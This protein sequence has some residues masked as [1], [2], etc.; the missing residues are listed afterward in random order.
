[1]ATSMAS[2]HSVAGDPVG[3][4]RRVY[5]YIDVHRYHLLR[6]LK[7][8][9]TDRP[10]GV[11]VFESLQDKFGFQAGN[12]ANQKE[13]LGHWVL[14]I[15]IRQQ[16]YA[17]ARA[18]AN[19]NV[20]S[21]RGTNTDSSVPASNQSKDSTNMDDGWDS[22]DLDTDD[23]NV[24]IHETMSPTLDA[25][26]A[27]RLGTMN[28]SEEQP[29]VQRFSGLHVSESLKEVQRKL[30]KNYLNWCDFVGVPEHEVHV[31]LDERKQLLR[32]RQ[33]ALWLLIWG[34]SANVRFMPE[35][36][37]FIY[38]NMAQGLDEVDL[39]HGEH[40]GLSVNFLDDVVTPI[41]RLM[42]DM[43]HNAR[44]D[45]PNPL[46]HKDVVNY[47]DVNEFFWSPVCLQFDHL[48]VASGIQARDFKKT[49]REKR[50]VFNPMLAF[51]RIWFFLVV[52][53]HI[54]VVIGYVAYR[55][56]PPNPSGFAFYDNIFASEMTDVRC[57][58]IYSIFVTISGLLLLKVVLQMWLHGM[59]LFKDAWLATGVFF[60]LVWHCF[61]VA[62]F[63]M[64]NLAPNEPF[65]IS[66]VAS[67][68]PVG[69]APG[70]YLACGAFFVLIYCI[71][72]LISAT[73]RMCF[74]NSL[75]RWAWFSG[76]DG[77]R[78]QYVGRDMRQP[79]KYTVMYGL[80]WLVILT[81]KCLFCLQCMV[82]PLIGSTIEIYDLKY[83]ANAHSN[84]NSVD[85]HN[86]L[87]ILALW[88]PI[89]IVFMYDS[90]IWFIVYQAIVGLIMGLF[91]KIGHCDT[92]TDFR[93]A[94]YKG[95]DL[96]DRTVAS[97]RMR[98][99]LLLIT[100]RDT[101]YESMRL[102]FAIVWNEIVERLWQGDLVSRR[103]LRNLQYRIVDNGEKVED[104]VFV[105]TGKL[106]KAIEIASKAEARKWD[107]RDLVRKFVE[108]DVMDG[109]QNGLELVKSIFYLI[110]GDKKIEPAVR[111]FDAFFTSLD[112]TK[113]VDFTNLPQLARHVEELLWEI[114]DAPR[115]LD[116]LH[117]PSNH[118]DDQDLGAEAR[119]HLDAYLAHVRKVVECMSNVRTTLRGMLREKRLRKRLDTCRFLKTDEN[120]NYD[121]TFAH[122]RSRL[123]E[124]YR[125]SSKR[126]ASTSEVLL[127]CER[128]GF[129]SSFI[130]ASPDTRGQADFLSSCIRLLSLLR[131]DDSLPRCEE[132]QRRL[133]FFLRSLSMK[134]PSVLSLRAM[135]SFAVMTPY[136]SE[137][138]MYN[139]EELHTEVET[140]APF[141]NVQLYK[142]NKVTT[143][144]YLIS[145]NRDEWNNFLE[146]MEI[147][148]T[149]KDMDKYDH[150]DELRLIR[151]ALSRVPD[152]VR[153]WA[154]MRAQ[155]LAR[156]VMGM[157]MY[158]DA[159]KLLRWLEIGNTP[160]SV[161]KKQKRTHIA[162]LKFSYI[163]GCQIFGKQRAEGKQQAH[164]I[165][166]LMRRFPSWRVSYMDEVMVNNTMQYY[167]VLCKA[168]GTEIVEIYRYRLPG[169]PILGEGKPENQNIALP[170]TRGEYIQTIDMNQEHYF[171]E[172][173]KI[174]NFL[175][176]A[177]S[178]GEEVTIIGMK[179]H[180][181]TGRA[182]SLARFMTMQELVFV[183]L[184]QRV[185]AKPL[186]SR[187]HYGHPD[188]FDKSFVMAN[189]GVSKA[190][191]GINLSEDVFSGYNVTLRGGVVTH[192]EFMQCGKGRDVTLSQIN[193]FETKLS[194]GCA[195][196]CLSREGH[197]LSNSLDFFRLNSMYY[198]HF[199]FY[200]CNALT[201]FCVYI[202]AYAKLYITT[203]D[204]IEAMAA[205]TSGSLDA[206]A[207]VINTQYILQFGF[208]TV[209]P[210]MATL[211]VEFGFKQA[212]FKNTEL[213]GALGVVFY[214]FLTGTK[215]HAF[216]SALIRGG[217]KY[218]ATGRGFSITRDP[219]VTFFKLYGVSHFRKA[220]ELI[221]IM[222][223]VGIFG[224][225]NV[226]ATA[227]STFCASADFSCSDH[228]E[229]IP[230][231][232]T[233]L[234]AFASSGQ[235]FGTTSFAVLLLGSCWLLAPFVFN[236]HGLSYSMC[237]L[238]VP[239]WF[240]W[241]MYGQGLSRTVDNEAFRAQIEAQSRSSQTSGASTR[242]SHTS[243]SRTLNSP[244]L[245]RPLLSSAQSH[246]ATNGLSSLGRN[247]SQEQA[248]AVLED[249]HAP[250]DGWINWWYEEV[251][252][253]W[254]L[255]LMARLTY[256]IRELR[257]FAAAYFV[258]H[259][260]FSDSELP[261]LVAGVFGA[262]LLLWA[263]SA[264]GSS[265]LEARL[266]YRVRGLLYM[267]VVIGALIT[268]PFAFGLAM[269]WRGHKALTLPISMLVTLHGITQ[270]GIL[271]HGAFGWAV[272]TTNPFMCLG[273]LFDM[274]LGIFLIVPILILSPIPFMTLLQNRLMYNNVFSKSLSSGS[275]V[276][277][278][279][280]IF[281]GSMA[282]Y[283]FGFVHA[284]IS[285]LGF[286]N[287]S[288]DNYVNRSFWYFVSNVLQG[289]ESRPLKTIL[290][291]GYLQ[292][293]CAATAFVAVLISL[294]L[295]RLGGRRIH[296][297]VG[298]LL[299]CEGI[300]MLFT[301][302]AALI[303]ISCAFICAGAGVVCLNYLLY[304]FEVCTR[305]WRGKGIVMFIVGNLGGY[306]VNALMVRGIN[307]SPA[308]EW[309]NTSPT[310][311]RMQ[312][313][314]GVLPVVI[315]G[316]LIMYAIPESPAWLLRRKQGPA[317]VTVLR[318]LR[319][320]GTV[321]DEYHALGQELARTPKLKKLVAPFAFVVL[322]QIIQGVMASN[323]LLLREHVRPEGETSTGL[324]AS[325]WWMVYYGGVT[326]VGAILSIGLID[327]SPRKLL[328]Q[329]SS[330][331]VGVLC[332]INLALTGIVSSRNSLAQVLLISTFLLSGLCMVGASWLSS[333]EMF[334]L[335][336]RPLCFSL[337]FSWFYLTQMVVY[338]AKPTL[339]AALLT[340]AVLCFILA[341]VLY[342]FGDSNTEG[343]Q[344]V[345][346]FKN[347]RPESNDR[348]GQEEHA[349]DEMLPSTDSSALPETSLRD[350]RAF[351]LAVLAAEPRRT[352]EE[353]LT[354]LMSFEDDV[355]SPTS[356]SDEV[357]SRRSSIARYID[358]SARFP[359]SRRPN[360]FNSI[361]QDLRE[362]LLSSSSLGSDDE[363]IRSHR[364]WN[365]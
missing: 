220:L 273:F 244:G 275:E 326:G 330:P 272:A 22:D 350:D 113:V 331:V 174:P 155:T 225:F 24:E 175:A 314:Y 148:K 150:D 209:L 133:G 98:S 67:F 80:S 201:V 157:M 246:A 178:S 2:P 177:T 329:Y 141:K 235:S 339:G 180:V 252:A 264:Y 38:H 243:P 158:E 129:N 251:E 285:G 110:L 68:I 173:L 305:D 343:D 321:A 43:Q 165:M 12:V 54:L 161:K 104:P 288:K 30:F 299:I 107:A 123:H 313:L 344:L 332:L 36:L 87:F 61:F 14:N 276:A 81:V 65:P 145:C 291:N 194:N 100:N 94:L 245:S 112:V 139:L 325:S 45:N 41:Y 179:E 338:L 351:D 363:L 77:H 128:R 189:G 56:A 96:F 257:H 59:R 62:L 358:G 238:D 154:S 71:P 50:S 49:F 323:V 34:E 121:P 86:L 198:G 265:V 146:R 4:P 185:L 310:K 138:V 156:T 63:A 52:M 212:L 294:A 79:A 200:I 106:A 345:I 204:D 97:K 347:Q 219:M 58:A 268:I 340:M 353:R 311:W 170:F 215:A 169:H 270:Y 167:A 301:S 290:Q 11:S 304:S 303:I 39:I 247:N 132:A 362:P 152:E 172:T 278:S 322:L 90:Q 191:K 274:I 336:V 10:R 85:D 256:A 131:M 151:E 196:S 207:T 296:M 223:L 40:A 315:V 18:S 300:G 328:L 91:M 103:E 35:C 318:N 320:N 20:S 229:M 236:T 29:R 76:L 135:P 237:K 6:H 147:I 312:P 206:L 234:Q 240:D 259:T 72:V 48:N 210:L 137:T 70:S 280:S 242:T 64:V 365:M 241:M 253:M 13:N 5:N 118:N 117:V 187:M 73:V 114:M 183:T 254:K 26:P 205:I 193:A 214:T 346:R 231:N 21:F 44:K 361:A 92:T 159:L 356:A 282:G 168:Q 293:I 109:V 23:E 233:A 16:E 248:S 55:S 297:I 136:Y 324:K 19:M 352:N 83:S 261:I 306:F 142:D 337:A 188:V 342:F 308:S 126:N 176:T 192:E 17:T 1:M 166:F 316:L 124:L 266:R 186:R 143:L 108:A 227:Y 33:I 228:P 359:N 153:L 317:A 230:D 298:A 66:E 164:D 160:E 111:V 283:M 226:G 181:Y 3:R 211:V 327:R 102:R 120:G 289:S 8:F 37:C 57:H 249:P 134:M 197:R 222:M 105:L 354:L 140:H 307:E 95:P 182:S 42:T 60:R 341:F 144:R 208:L 349:L 190:S 93:K 213:I 199:G 357:R 202:Y 360:S 74:A 163:T 101:L 302:S 28:S 309:D 224:N 267:V 284:F 195:E 69:G 149:V 116:E 355:T 216:D 127:K 88:A 269:G 115:G 51:F 7:A 53:F 271:L 162:A 258:F 119:G 334:P 281:L 46:D 295:S 15:A 286:V 82:K 221:G 250:K 232:V 47:D 277:A 239:F 262:W 348:H 130:S 218:R 255:G 122:Q 27:P 84:G 333:L 279:L 75:R 260:Q 31:E 89:F 335:V 217:S 9:R 263:A 99:Q 78:G 319:L 287:R 203:H 32:E 364:V 171:E 25:P 184:T 125:A 292:V